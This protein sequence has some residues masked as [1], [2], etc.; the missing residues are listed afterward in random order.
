MHILLLSPKSKYLDQ[1]RKLS[2]QEH[3]RLVIVDDPKRDIS[4]NT[5]KED[6]LLFGSDLPFYYFHRFF[7]RC[8]DGLLGD[9][10]IL[11]DGDFAFLKKIGFRY[12]PWLKGIHFHESVNDIPDIGIRPAPYNRFSNLAEILKNWGPPPVRYE[13]IPS[14]FPQK[15]QIQTTTA[16]EANCPYCPRVHLTMEKG[17]MD[18]ELF[19]KI[20]G[21]CAKGKAEFIE[22][23]FHAESLLDRRLERLATTAKEQCPDAHIAIISK[24]GVMTP[25]RAKALAAGGLDLA[26]ISV[27]V[28]EHQEE[29]DLTRRLSNISDLSAIFSGE[30]KQLVVV[31]LENFLPPKTKGLFRKLCKE[32]GL[33]LESFRATSRSGDA[34][35]DP[36]LARKKNIST[37]LCE[38]PFTKAYIRYNGDVVLCCEDWRYRRVLGNATHDSLSDIW[39]G[40][41]FQKARQQLLNKK[42][43]IPCS[44]CDYV[45]S[46]R[47]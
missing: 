2:Q 7:F 4:L 41:L 36:F 28:T 25:H 6:Q 39:T 18:I 17:T 29:K 16:C 22:L 46:D 19:E 9:I 31:T 5:D 15:L 1:G 40:P 20:I 45:I 8:K 12:R 47:G 38:R 10:R 34:D 33:R 24:E 37:R 26:F 27:N 44:V 32:L 23:Y 11:V 21:Q 14:Q 43:D 30:G 3:C 42:P 35:I 13:A